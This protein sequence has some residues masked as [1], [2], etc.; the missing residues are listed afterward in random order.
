MRN[1]MK[2]VLTRPVRGRGG[3]KFLEESKGNV[4]IPPADAIRIAKKIL[5]A[6]SEAL[7][8]ICKVSPRTVHG[9]TAGRRPGA[10]PMRRL[11][12]AVNLAAKIRRAEKR[13]AKRAAKLLEGK[14]EVGV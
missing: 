10:L 4:E 1:A 2:I 13:A 12:E 11:F 7:A 5:G 9:W 14:T 8:E 3:F 6:D